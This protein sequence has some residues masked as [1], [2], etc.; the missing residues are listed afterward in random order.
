MARI[1]ILQHPS[2]TK[3]LDAWSVG[4]LAQHWR[5]AHEVVV[6][7]RFRR[8]PPGDIAILHVDLS[9]V[10]AALASVAERYGRVVNGRA[11]DIRK[12][13]VSR[14]LVG[15]DDDWDG[16]VIVKTDLNYGGIPERA[17]WRHQ[18]LLRRLLSRRPPAVSPD[19]PIYS[20][21]GAVPADVWSNA[22]LVVER[23]LPELDADGFA[24]RTWLFFGERERCRRFV[25]RTPIVK[26]GNIVRSDPATVPPALRR[27]RARLGIDY[28][29]FDF[30]LRGD[31]ATLLDA[32]K[33][34][35]APPPSPV[36]MR[37]YAELADGIEPMLRGG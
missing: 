12:R 14:N 30:V 26:S 33:T 20:D 19:Y 13:L 32:N 37:L 4:L 28:G 24:I 21:R 6:S 9:V 7:G 1:V 17:H 31:E 36:N 29:K 25:A 15:R 27:D 35:S 3:R 18:S 16:P 2:E 5:H 10:P 22:D 34:P 11:L 8:A 23:F